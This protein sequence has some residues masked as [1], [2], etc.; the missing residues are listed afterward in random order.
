MDYRP[1]EYL[2]R[3]E[4]L[5]KFA[6]WQIRMG[7][8]D[9][10]LWM[11][12]YIF[13]RQEYNQEQVLW[14]IWLYANTYQLPTAYVM[15][16]EFPDY[17]LVDIKR[18]TAWNDENYHRLRY[19]VDC[20]YNKGHLPAMFESYQSV[21]GKDQA[22]FFN[23]L[24]DYGSGDSKDNFKRIWDACSE[25]H[26]FGRYKL[27]FYIQALRDVAGLNIDVPNLMLADSGSESHRDGLCAGIGKDQW[28]KKKIV[29]D[30]VKV[31]IRH[32]FQ[33][34]DYEL[35]ELEAA[36]LIADIN[37][38]LLGT[39]FECD[40]FLF[41]TILCAFKKFFRRRDGRY[42]GYYL[43]R[44]YEDIKRVQNDG[45]DGIEWKLLWDARSEL[46]QSDLI[47]T[48]GVSADRMCHFLDH[49]EIDWRG[50]VNEQSKPSNSLEGFFL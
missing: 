17:D 28:M 10:S 41:E 3:R 6:V 15:A 40:G 46:I 31:K 1:N 32:N 4:L 16:N 30:G 19:Q 35:L 25:F 45:W 20:R 9:P 18:L 8:V 2:L 33:T 48:N 21:V 12:R 27:W 7:D 47:R 42:C 34:S 13:N 37:H 22:A 43:D 44:Q 14:Y 49:G 29:K 11:M 36:A 50:L 24:C 23:K 26:L 5:V 38:E 39:G